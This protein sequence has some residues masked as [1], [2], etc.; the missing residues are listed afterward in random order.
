MDEHKTPKNAVGVI[1]LRLHQPRERLGLVEQTLAVLRPGESVLFLYHEP[2]DR[3]ARYIST[4]L[5]GEFRVM[6]LDCGPEIWS[7]MVQ[8]VNQ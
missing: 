7:L 2:P 1:D 6:E 3:L 8:A 4:S 5:S